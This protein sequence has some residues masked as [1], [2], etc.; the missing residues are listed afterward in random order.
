MKSGDRL[1]RYIVI[2]LA[3]ICL[4]MADDIERGNVYVPYADCSFSASDLQ[5]GVPRNSTYTNTLGPSLQVQRQNTG[6]SGRTGFTIMK[7]GKSMNEYSTSLFHKSIIR[8]PSGMNETSRR[9]IGL[10]KLII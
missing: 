9:L 5:C 1:I 4:C 2:C 8:F 10:G 7:T 6:N 3:A